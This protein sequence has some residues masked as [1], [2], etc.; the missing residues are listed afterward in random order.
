[1]EQLEQITE[2]TC[3]FKIQ[4]M[5]LTY[6]SE[7][8]EKC[9]SVCSGKFYESCEKYKPI[10]KVSSPIRRGATALYSF[11]LNNISLK[12]LTQE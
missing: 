5:R 1:M 6:V 4:A 12:S 3:I 2:E 11:W 10:S 7:Q 8:Q 9:R